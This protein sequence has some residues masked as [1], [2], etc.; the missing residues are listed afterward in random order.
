MSL[1]DWIT[2]VIAAG[3]FVTTVYAI[4]LT[5]K[6]RKY[7]DRKKK[8][9][10]RMSKQDPNYVGTG[11]LD[12]KRM[13]ELK[14]FDWLEVCRENDTLKAEIARLRAEPPTIESEK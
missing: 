14:T 6:D 12:Y 4:Y 1:S 9:K 13:L 10:E 11:T 5:W 3:A 7:N 2:I 8:E